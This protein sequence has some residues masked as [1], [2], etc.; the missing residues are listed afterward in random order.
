MIAIVIVG[1][2]RI[3]A[4]VLVG[5][6]L[7]IRKVPL[8]FVLI[9]QSVEGYATKNYCAHSTT[10]P[11]VVVVVFVVVCHPPLRSFW[12]MLAFRSARCRKRE[13]APKVY[14]VSQ[15]TSKLF[16]PCFPQ[17][18][19]CKLRVPRSGLGGSK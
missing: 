14:G 9:T 3:V 18:T 2:V 8:H 4:V 7:V 17:G 12:A 13:N 5:V 10:Q 1:V 19:E 16:R 6:E 11:H 15:A